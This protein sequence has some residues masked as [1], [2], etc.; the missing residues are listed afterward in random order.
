M[1][2]RKIPATY[3]EDTIHVEKE[4]KKRQKKNMKT[5]IYE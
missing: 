1:N 5:S 2:E 4:R 3:M